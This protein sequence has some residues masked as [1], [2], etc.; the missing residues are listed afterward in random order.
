MAT[1]SVLKRLLAGADLAPRAPVEGVE[2]ARAPEQVPAR[3][4][5][6][7]ADLVDV[8]EADIL[9]AKRPFRAVLSRPAYPLTR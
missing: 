8:L 2:T 4:L 1:L 5:S 7:D 3:A 9:S 6:F